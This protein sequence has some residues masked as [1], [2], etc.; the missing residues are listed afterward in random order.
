MI[1]PALLDTDIF[2][3][4]MRAKNSVVLANARDYRSRYGHYTISSVTLT[5]LVKGFVRSGRE[6]RISYL[7]EL[8]KDHEILPFDAIA[9][10]LAG[11]IFGELERAGQPIGRVDPFIAAIAVRHSLTLVTGNTRHFKRI[12]DLGF[13]LK[14]ANWREE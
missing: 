5:E 9:A 13:P 4:T 1:P 10:K 8:L 14:L 3:E 7:E 11:R 6:D 2:S 12:V